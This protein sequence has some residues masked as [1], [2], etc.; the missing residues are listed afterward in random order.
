MIKENELKQL[1]I[2]KYNLSDN[3]KIEIEKIDYLY[4]LVSQYSQRFTLMRL[5]AKESDVTCEL[6]FDENN[7]NAAYIFTIKNGNEE[8]LFYDSVQAEAI[9]DSIN[10]FYKDKSLSQYVKS[11]QKIP[12]KRRL[13][14]DLNNSWSDYYKS[15]EKAVKTKLFRIIEHND[16]FYLKSI[17]SSLFKEY[18]IA[19]SFV[20]AVLEL[21]KIMVSNSDVDFK[22]SSIS[23]SESKL[24]L[25]ISQKKSVPLGDLG[26]LRSSI[27]VRNEDQ[28]NTSFGVYSTL[29]FFPKSNDSKKIYLFPKQD[30]NK[31]RNSISSKHTVSNNAFLE[32]FS[33]IGELFNLG[34]EMK[35]DFE[36]YK[37]SKSYDELRSKIEHRLITNNS[38]FK[39]IKEL[40]DLFSREKTG[41]IDNLE[42]LLRIC[43]ESDNIEMEYDL[44]FKLR[45][46]IS[47]V[48]LYNS[49]QY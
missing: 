20:V 26:F 17:N 33:K 36:F 31:I 40:K 32:T 24:D 16:K 43:A 6:I 2:N 38:P 14:S 34:E 8:E 29:E 25:I 46:L 48:L 27:S 1:I 15:N 18:G 41:H 13:M 7:K 11:L 10:L 21:N 39:K 19:E 30:E 35:N 9:Y 23:I 42:T 4:D 47:N 3:V 12:G 44:K 22:I 45:Y 28:G 37:G 5:E 49:N